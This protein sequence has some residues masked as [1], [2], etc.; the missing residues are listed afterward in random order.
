M[1]SSHGKNVAALVKEDKDLSKLPGIGKSMMEK[2]K[3]I[4]HN[5]TLSQLR[6]LE[7]RVPPDLS[8][9]MN[10]SGLGPKKVQ[11]LYREVGVETLDDLRQ[12]ATKKK[13]RELEGF[14]KKTEEKILREAE[15]ADHQEKRFKLAA[16]EEQVSSLED[17][18]KKVK[19][20]K[21]ITVAGSYRRKK[22]TVGD[23]D[24]LATCKKGSR[25]MARFAE[26]E[27]VVEVIAR[28]KTRSSVVLRSGLQVDLRVAPQ[29]SYGAALH[30]CTGSK[31]HNIAVR[32]LGQQRNLKINDYG[33]FKGKKRVAGKTEKELYAKVDMAYIEPELREN[34]GELEASTT[35]K[36]PCLISLENMRGDLHAHTKETDGRHSLEEMAE[37]ARDRG[38]RI[39]DLK[40]ACGMEHGA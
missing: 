24:I 11:A 2:I 12:A 20:V 36:L 29:V 26:Y 39:A 7:G 33:V 9:L 13:I 35:K 21:S 38:L 6:E 31:E 4:V 23:L 10:L 18:L 15:K 3:E 1:V 25:V 22:E 40:K 30:Y 14:D 27:D 17:Y 34:R 32:K 16:V 8:K 5:D 19:G 28:G 37:A